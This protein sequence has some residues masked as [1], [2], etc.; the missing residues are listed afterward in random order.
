LVPRYQWS[1]RQ[2]RWPDGRNEEDRHEIEDDVAKLDQIITDTDN[3][4]FLHEDIMER[5]LELRDIGPTKALCYY[6]YAVMGGFCTSPHALRES[7]FAILNK[8]NPAAKLL[9]SSG[10]TDLQKALHRMSWHYQREQ[11]C[12]ENCCCKCTRPDG[13]CKDYIADGQTLYC[14]VKE[15]KDKGEEQ[16]VLF[17]RTPGFPWQQFTPRLP[18]F[19]E[20]AA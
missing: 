15:C 16:T 4:K 2:G 18:G 14:K 12:T 13:F 17:K 9:E 7:H 8:G 1:S 10:C 3:E 20:V 6:N 11:D 5:L 19:G